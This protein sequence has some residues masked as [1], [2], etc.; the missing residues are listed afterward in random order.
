MTSSQFHE[1][2]ID[3][4]ITFIFLL[5]HLNLMTSFAARIAIKLITL[6]FPSTTD[7]VSGEPLRTP[8]RHEPK[9]AAGEDR[10]EPEPVPWLD[11]ARMIEA[12]KAWTAPVAQ[13]Y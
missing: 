5:T 6:A 7:P 2:L 8:R 11:A 13:M 4:L 3:G 1:T 9:R 10:K 12:S